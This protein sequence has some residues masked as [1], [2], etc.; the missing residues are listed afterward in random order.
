MFEAGKGGHI[1]CIIMGY[2]LTVFLSISF[3]LMGA[4]CWGARHQK[5]FQ[6]CI[7]LFLV[8][9]SSLSPSPFLHLASG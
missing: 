9:A 1:F 8:R 5:P 3:L 6:N 2:E 7:V 4:L